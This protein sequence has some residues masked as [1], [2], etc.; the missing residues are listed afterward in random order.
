MK[1]LSL[2]N[3][4]AGALQSFDFVEEHRDDLLAMFNHYEQLQEWREER[5]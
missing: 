3:N 2:E 4:H 5:E 1:R